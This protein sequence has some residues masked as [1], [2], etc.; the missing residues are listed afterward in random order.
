MLDIFNFKNIFFALIV[1]G[2]S[3]VLPAAPQIIGVNV[4]IISQNNIPP[5]F[6]VYRPDIAGSVGTSDVCCVT[7]DN[8]VSMGKDGMPGSYDT[9]SRELSP[10]FYSFDN[11]LETNMGNHGDPNL[12]FDFFT[13]RWFY[14]ALGALSVSDGPELSEINWKKFSI[15]PGYSNPIGNLAAIDPDYDQLGIDQYALIIGAANP[16]L[17]NAGLILIVQKE[18]VLNGGP[19]IMNNFA[20]GDFGVSPIGVRNFD[21][22]PPY[23]YAIGVNNRSGGPLQIYRFAATDTPNPIFVD[24]IGFNLPYG[25]GPG[26]YGVECFDTINSSWEQTPPTNS[27]YGLPAFGGPFIDCRVMT[28]AHIRDNQLYFCQM[29]REISL[30]DAIIARWYQI[31]LTDPANPCLVQFGDIFA[32]NPSMP[33]LGTP[34]SNYPTLMTNTISRIVPTSE[35]GCP[36]DVPTHN[37]IIGFTI[38]SPN[39]FQL[40]AAYFIYGALPTTGYFYNSNTLGRLAT[41][42]LGQVQSFEALTN[43]TDGFYV[44]YGGDYSYSALDPADQTTMWQFLQWCTSPGGTYAIQ[45]TQLI[46]P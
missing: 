43:T 29:L 12:I 41:D 27:F 2:M 7:N 28:P 5:S 40:Y 36:R 19:I 30:S 44:T 24:T 11:P 23:S 35:S 16:S 46:N 10:F 17:N 33:I 18:S 34:N 14:T 22:N 45:A 6:L 20:T 4:P 13:Q 25:Q 1:L 42:P 37:M 26:A 3:V 15:A 32:P 21:S 38:G 8:L 39:P 31:D 9:Y